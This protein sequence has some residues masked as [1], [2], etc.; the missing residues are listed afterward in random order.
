M[1][2]SQLFYLPT[3][4]DCPAI[5]R[6]IRNVKRLAAWNSY[7]YQCKDNDARAQKK[8]S[9]EIFG[10][11][12]AGVYAV[13]TVDDKTETDDAKW[14][15]TIW[16]HILG[17]FHEEF[18]GW[19]GE[20]YMTDN[21]IRM[22]ERNGEKPLAGPFPLGFVRLEKPCLVRVIRDGGY[23]DARRENIS[24]EMGKTLNVK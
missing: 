8:L 5:R 23:W 13:F 6:K 18:N 20:V 7:R 21:G 2:V 14:G 19:A 3:F 11:P 17:W 12:N 9:V 22:D 4:Y 1:K 24:K 10:Q 15:H 16:E